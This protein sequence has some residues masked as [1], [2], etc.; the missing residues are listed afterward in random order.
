MAD[1]PPPASGGGDGEVIPG[2]SKEICHHLEVV[3]SGA[4]IKLT[5]GLKYFNGS[6]E[7]LSDIETHSSKYNGQ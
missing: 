4:G 3:A 2:D 1:L 5:D 6:S 7:T